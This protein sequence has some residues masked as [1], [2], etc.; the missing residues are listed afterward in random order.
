MKEL[1][2]KSQQYKT[3]AKYLLAFQKYSPLK[4]E[5]ESIPIGRKRSSF[6]ARYET[7]LNAYDL[8]GRRLA[9]MNVNTNVDPE[10]VIALVKDQDGKVS[11][12]SGELKDISGRIAQLRNAQQLL[13]S[14]KE[15]RI[16]ERDVRPKAE[17]R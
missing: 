2:D 6:A 14:L 9:E 1:S 8:A 15:D 13:A 3:A 11:K 16:T 10:K 12:L 7:E 4:V 5:Y 17:E